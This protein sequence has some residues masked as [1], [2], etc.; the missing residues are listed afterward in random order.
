[1]KKGDLIIIPTDTVYGFAAMLHDEVALE[2]LYQIM[3]SEQSRQIP[4]LISK[5]SHLAGIAETT[6]LSRKIMKTF[7]PGPLTMVMR[8]TEEFYAKTGERTIAARM[9]DH[10]LA[11]QLLTTYGVLRSTSLN[12]NDEQPLKDFNQIKA[13]YGS[14]VS[15]IYE[16][17]FNQTDLSSTVIDMTGSSYVVIREGNI[18]KEDLDLELKNFMEFLN[19]N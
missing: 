9:P 1:V 15:E 16:Q 17:K 7:W 10:Q 11:K 19:K 4:I 13:L 14:N 2:K 8:T 3:G 5:M 12:K 18:K 6:V